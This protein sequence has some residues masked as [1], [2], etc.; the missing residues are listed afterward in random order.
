M[1]D[2]A[3]ARME[4]AFDRLIGGIRPVQM[5]D[6]PSALILRQR[7]DRLGVEQR[8][9]H[10]VHH[11]G[12]HARV[13]AEPRH[14]GGTVE[15]HQARRAADAVR[16]RGVRVPHEHLGIVPYHVQI[17]V[18][19]ETDGIVAA[20]GGDDAVDGR[21]GERRQQVLRPRPRV[22]CQ[23]CGLAQGVRGLGHGDPELL[24]ELP[25]A[26]GVAMGN[27]ARPS[28]GQRDRRYAAA[29]AAVVSA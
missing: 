8:S 2:P 25:L 20:D 15:G 16:Y 28:P 11:V 29:A 17:E 10:G 3:G 13:L 4:L 22:A 18:R 1:E 24:L 6:G 7:A 12:E 9:A 14:E 21:V 27:R 19:Q 5:F 26:G 23:P